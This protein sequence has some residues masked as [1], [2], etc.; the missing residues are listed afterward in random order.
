MRVES[1]RMG[2]GHFHHMRT[3]VRRQS[4]RSRDW[5]LTDA[6]SAAGALV[7]GFQPPGL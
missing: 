2:L 3:H 7:S 5:S 1:S 4:L 6:E